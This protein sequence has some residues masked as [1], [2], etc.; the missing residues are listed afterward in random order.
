MPTVELPDG[1]TA[2]K[3]G[4]FAEC[5]TSAASA[6]VPL[7]SPWHPIEVY[8]DPDG[9]RV[10]AWWYQDCGAAAGIVA[11]GQPRPDCDPAK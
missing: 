1:L 8:G 4:Y 10:V 3:V 5:D 7:G 9:D 2:T 6:D 11:P